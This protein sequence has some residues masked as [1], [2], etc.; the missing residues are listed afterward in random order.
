MLMLLDHR[1]VEPLLELASSLRIS[2]VARQGDG[3]GLLNSGPQSAPLAALF[4]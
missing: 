3:F 2:V 1:P 4:D